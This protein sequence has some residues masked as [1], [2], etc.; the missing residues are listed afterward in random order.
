MKQQKIFAAILCT[1][2][3]LACAADN[4]TLDEIVVTAT[5]FDSAPAAS[6][7]NVTVITAE[8]IKKSA[9]KT[10]PALLTQH[11]GIQVR[12][13]DG[14]PDMMIDMRGF[15]MSGN[16]NTLVLLDGQPLNNIELTSIAWSA[17]PLDSIA[18]IEIINGGGAVLYGAGASGGTINIIT[19]RPGKQTERMV[20]AGL[21]SYNSK[22]WQ[23]AVGLKGEQTG[24]RISASAL[25]SANYRVNNNIEQSNLEADVRTVAG[26]GDIALKFG[27]DGQ[28]LRYPGARR[29]DPGTGQNQLATDPR[30]ATTP[31][32]YGKRQSGHVSL[33]TS[34][35]FE[36][37][38]LAAEL[39][40]RD[41]KSQAYFDYGIYGG[42]YLDT[43]LNRLS[44]SPRA[45]IP[46]QLG[47]IGNELVVGT[48][49]ANWD[50]DSIRSTSPASISTP[51]AHI[52]TRQLDRAVYAQNTTSLG[53]ATKLTLGGRIQHTDY[54][55]NDAVNPAAYASGN[56][57]RRVN[58]YEFGLRHDLD[59]TLAVF[60]RIGSSFR[61]ATVDETFDPY[62]G[63]SFDSRITLLQPQTS[64]DKEVGLDYKNGSSRMR[65]T[66]YYMDLKNEIHYNAITYTNMNLSPTRRYGLELEGGHSYTDAIEINAAFSYTVAKFRE[67]IYGGVNVSGNDIPLVPRQRLTLGARWKLSEK[68]ALNGE[69]IYVSKQHFDNDQAN[70]FGQ[71]MPAY[72]TV[73][74]KMSHQEKCWSLTA[75]VNNLFNEKYFTYAIAGAA[76]SGIYNAYPMPERNF[77]LA[78]KY[79]Y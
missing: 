54:Q 39:S 44:F 43:N 27:A 7:L 58:V 59:P 49:L 22:E 37:G 1:A 57:G 25:D 55:A 45:K 68:T 31:L 19:K 4:N 28:N 5:R 79:R 30:G 16:Q 46:Y 47:G 71:Q 41:K 29:V 20:S 8:D 51:T 72:T 42:S 48:D 21:G 62:G 73:D 61:M 63:L 77:S 56:Q 3:P 65:A 34:Q 67:G 6:S 35:Q 9:A 26:Y 17:I 40:Y 52:L 75:A 60:G 53:A 23:V 24:M 33:G 2:T 69:A 32:D 70:T 64:Q 11:A 15:G 18:R 50:Y 12:S 66:F 76:A 38:E 10:L 13:N 14:T 74:L 78:V 36:F